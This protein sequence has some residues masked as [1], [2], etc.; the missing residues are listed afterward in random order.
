M[1]HV[2]IL[3]KTLQSGKSEKRSQKFATANPPIGGSEVRSQ[4]S[5]I[6]ALTQL[7]AIVRNNIV[8]LVGGGA[9]KKN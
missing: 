9:D 1:L 6:G 4:R 5:E 2:A 7:I 8:L 3:T